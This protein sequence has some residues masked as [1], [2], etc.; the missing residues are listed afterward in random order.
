LLSMVSTA[1]LPCRVLDMAQFRGS[2]TAAAICGSSGG[3]AMIQE[4]E[5]ALLA[6]LPTPAISTIGGTISCKEM[7]LG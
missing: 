6:I 3:W 5:R 4:R 2:T 7:D 1:A